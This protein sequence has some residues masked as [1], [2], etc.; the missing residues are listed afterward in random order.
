MLMVYN[1]YIYMEDK[2]PKIIKFIGVYARVSTSNQEDQK[3]VEAQLS[4]VR[5]YANKNNY[6]IVK[7]YVD[8]GWSG[9]ILARP[10]LDQLRHDARN[11]AFD[12]VLI[13]DPDRL[14][15]RLFYQQIVI[16]ELKQLDIEILF[17]TMPPIKNESDELM[18]GI[19]GLFA[20]YEK[21]KITERFRIGKVNR[22]KNN[23]ILVSEG[24]YGYTYIL[25]KGK[26]GSSDY[27]SGHLEINE[28]E[29][30]IV[31][32]IFNWVACDKLTLRAVVRRLQELGIQPRKSKRGVWNT[33]TLTSLLR[34]ETYIGI[35][36]WGAS[37]A[38]VPLKTTNKDEY[39]KIK[40]S[41]RR[42]KEKNLW[43]DITSVPVIVDK[44]IF[45]MARE[46]L[47]KNFETLGRNKK[48]DYLLAGK[49]WCN[50]GRRRAGE[51]PQQGKHLYYR[52]TDRVYSFPLPRTC[53]EHG[54]NARIVD[55]VTWKRLKMIMSS[56]K[57]LLDQIERWNEKKKECQNPNS[58]ID[59]QSTQDEISKLKKQEF[60]LA[61]LYSK[62]KIS[63]EQ[64]EEFTTP[65]RIKVSEYENQIAKA[66]LEKTPKNEILFP[67]RDEIEVFAQKATQYLEKISFKAKQEV[68]RTVVNQT[69]ASR[70]SL[71]AYGF[72]NLNEIYVKLF[73][74][75]RNRRF[76]KRGEVHTI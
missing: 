50:C 40:K 8:E 44:V 43:R 10:M 48:N 36:H 2:I 68:I 59:I 52:C 63:L 9:D 35:A 74:S 25:N 42:M 7:E 26:R 54:I 19:R 1:I 6:I 69:T 24:P 70:T 28:Y 18:F 46:Q 3:T 51:G 17:V 58:M 75:D 14:G 32:M 53:I 66:N 29:A 5:A 33:S 39:R 73:S 57:L 71:Q 20:Q 60:R 55:D 38:T 13:Y 41:S 11:K 21:A 12:A 31:R 56:P 76:A 45:E 22:V 27:V 47:K 67:S 37:Y 62:E 49:I 34:N 61:D 72:F 30:S 16:D 4:E 23:Q 64:F 15:R 65:L